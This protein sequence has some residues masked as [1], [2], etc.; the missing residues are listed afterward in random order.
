MLFE[1]L[2]PGQWVLERISGIVGVSDRHYV[3]E[4]P[5]VKTSILRFFSTDVLQF[6]TVALNV[7]LA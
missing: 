6:L 4:K 1:V 7:H 3:V 5:L 2:G